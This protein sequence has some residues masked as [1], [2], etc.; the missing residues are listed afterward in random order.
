MFF[1]NEQKTQP[2]DV[3]LKYRI[4]NIDDNYYTFSKTFYDN[5]EIKYEGY[6]KNGMYHGEGTLRDNNEKK[7]K[8]TFINGFYWNEENTL[9]YIDFDTNPTIFKG[10]MKNETFF[11]GV[12]YIYE[13]NDFNDI[14]Y[15]DF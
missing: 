8:G 9:Q 15:E 12:E 13:R 3:R 5:G 7:Y 6:F 10:S 4:K 14:L 1:E 2:A 11:T